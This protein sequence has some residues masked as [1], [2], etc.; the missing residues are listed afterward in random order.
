[1]TTTQLDARD[2]KSW[3]DAF[4]HPL[5]VVRKLELQLRRNIDANREQLR[6]VV[7]SSYRELLGTADRIIEMDGQMT[8]VE[9]LLADMGR[10]CNTRAVEGVGA[11]S[12]RFRAEELRRLEEGMGLGV[13]ARVRVVLGVLGVVGRVV[14]RGRDPLVAAKVLV[15]GRLVLRSLGEE[16]RPP[17]VLGE[18]KRRFVG[19]RRRLLGFVE[20]VLVAKRKDGAEGGLVNTLCA[21]ALVTSSGTKDV[22]RHFLQVR[23]QLL[24][25]KAEEPGEE[26]VME[27]LEVYARTLL[28]V[29]ELFPRRLAA[30]LTEL[31][32]Q[33]LLKD[34]QVRGIFELNL[35]LYEQWVTEDVR[36]FTPYARQD[37]LN[38]S[39]AAEG[40]RAWAGQVQE[41]IVTAARGCLE[42]QT[43]AE[44][45]LRIRHEML[46]TSLSLS[47]RL[48]DGSHMRFIENLREI[49]LD[50][51]RSL[52]RE[53]VGAID[54][55]LE[56]LSATAS[57]GL[58]STTP[59]NLATNDIDLQNGATA[60]R[61]TIVHNHF[62]QDEILLKSCE[63]LDAWMLKLDSLSAITKEMRATRWDDEL[64]LDFDD[65]EG[66]TSLQETLSK[67]DPAM[68]AD[69]L[70][71]H[72]QAAL[73]TAYQDMQTRDNAAA[74]STS[75]IRLHRE[76][77]QRQRTLGD[78]LETPRIATD[79][80]FLQ[81]LHQNLAQN[82]CEEPLKRFARSS[83]K[84][85]HVSTALWDGIPPLPVQP[86]PTGIRFL[87]ELHGAMAKAGNDVWSPGAVTALQNEV[88]ERLLE[89]SKRQITDL[90]PQDPN[91]EAGEDGNANAR[92]T[93]KAKNRAL[94]ALFDALFLFRACGKAVEGRG[95]QELD[96]MA[97]SFRRDNFLSDEGIARLRKSANDYWKRT[98][99]L[100]GLLAPRAS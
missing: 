54:I 58:L 52:A 2:L 40:L 19:L 1:M 50:R 29:R 13:K 28:D 53:L 10:K 55:P 31:S 30:A 25:G 8:R 16:E 91:D 32:R 65:L 6:S 18:L 5:P 22:M 76:L 84:R 69:A 70:R 89:V 45:V 4:Q 97:V 60:F 20:R 17:G 79:A 39:D 59:W 27:M 26:E 7:G 78:W 46:S 51:L 37:G 49:L 94:Q 77:D 90:R 21:Y 62:G 74:H 63:A 34:E 96:S 36:T 43:S 24:E 48:K 87:T 61:Q 14:K 44:T 92:P 66:E 72:A 33:P 71:I 85:K 41:Q 73:K 80:A 88:T 38:S 35:D 9:S 64:D 98:Y 42:G 68:L 100:F 67:K 23:F 86:S 12:A 15:L 47:S 99:L 82:V 75:L 3:E 81:S 93:G 83:G 95:S 11:G 56:Q 57:T